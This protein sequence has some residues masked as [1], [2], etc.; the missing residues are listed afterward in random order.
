[1][2][3]VRVDSG[4]SAGTTVSL[5]YDPMLAKVIAWAPHRSEALLRLDRALA[6]TNILGLSTNIA[7][8]RELLASP[9]VMQG[10]LHTGLAEQVAS[11][12]GE[13]GPPADALA[14]AALQWLLDAEPSCALTDPWDIPDGW[15]LGEDAWAKIWLTCPRIKTAEIRIRGHAGQRAEVSIDG[16]E[17][18]AARAVYDSDRRGLE[19]TYGGVM[20]RYL[21]ARA[22][23]D[24]RVL[25]IGHDGKAWELRADDGPPARARRASSDDGI[26]RSPM[27]GAVIAVRIRAGERVTAGQPLLVVEAMKMEHPVVSPTDG[28]VSE[29]L[30]RAGQQVD[31]DETV[32]VILAEE[33]A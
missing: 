10:K 28:L 26:V 2:P 6:S 12:F 11:E 19:I 20:R 22:D 15:R 14:G 4:L 27:P 3:H 32:A 30:V 29:I 13:T 16:A 23:G 8:L 25:W 1:M 33:A 5:S 31:M 9:D 18:V 7:F 24:R 21:T 17:P